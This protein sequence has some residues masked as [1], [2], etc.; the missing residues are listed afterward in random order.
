[1]CDM[2]LDQTYCSVVLG[3]LLAGEA[4]EGS[5]EGKLCV[6]DEVHEVLG[7]GELVQVLSVDHVAELVLNLDHQLDHIE[8]VEAVLSEGGLEGNLGLLGGA[9]VVLHNADHIL[10]DLIVVL[11]NEGALLGL[12][13]IL[14]QR[15][16]ATLAISSELGDLTLEAKAVE[17]HAL[18]HGNHSAGG[19]ASHSH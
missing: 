12:C 18:G 6:V 15:D 2:I 16:L 8:G 13:A 9:E 14:P 1:M 10:L 11:E 19:N 3:L 5:A 7:L 4:G 17:E